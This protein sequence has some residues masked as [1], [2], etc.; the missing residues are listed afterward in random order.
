MCS[1]MKW[2]IAYRELLHGA[3][4][5]ALQQCGV[6]EVPQFNSMR[7]SVE[8]TLEPLAGPQPIYCFHLNRHDLERFP[9]YL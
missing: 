2:P 1:E 4:P 8:E 9:G 5:P 3:V 7:V 6:L